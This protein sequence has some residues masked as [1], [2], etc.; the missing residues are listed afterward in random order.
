MRTT[1][2]ARTANRKLEVRINIFLGLFILCCP[3]LMVWAVWVLTAGGF[4]T[5]PVFLHPVFNLCM[6]L[7]Q[8]YITIPCWGYIWRKPKV[9]RYSVTPKPKQYGK[10]SH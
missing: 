9:H 2:T 8:Y 3:H 7:W 6:L 10:A 4:N 1:V 5:T